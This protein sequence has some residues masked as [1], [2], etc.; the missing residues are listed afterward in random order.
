VLIVTSKEVIVVNFRESF[1]SLLSVSR[2]EMLD[3]TFLWAFVI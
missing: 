1:A 2:L 3:A